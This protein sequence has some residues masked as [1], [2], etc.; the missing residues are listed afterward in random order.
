MGLTISIKRL[1]LDCNSNFGNSVK[2]LSFQLP[3]SIQMLLLHG[4]A[5][6]D[7]TDKTILLHFTVHFSAFLYFSC[8]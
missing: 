1:D 4:F 6:F 7:R 5:H 3:K 2:Q 8:F